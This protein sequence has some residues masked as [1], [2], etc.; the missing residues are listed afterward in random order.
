MDDV[1]VII[2]ITLLKLMINSLRQYLFLLTFCL[3][4][5]LLGL[6]TQRVNWFCRTDRG[7]N[8]FNSI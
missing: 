1:L 6:R 3:A 7:A 5:F 2:R 4:S 8:N